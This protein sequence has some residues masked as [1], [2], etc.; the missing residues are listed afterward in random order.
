LEENEV[1]SDDDLD[2]GSAI[3]IKSIKAGNLNMQEQMNK[4]IT[5]ILN[6]SKIPK[7]DIANYIL[8]INFGRRWI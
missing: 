4:R 8:D 7:I 3:T 5:D 2:L 6:K 1:S